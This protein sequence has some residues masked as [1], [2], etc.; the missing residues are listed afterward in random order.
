MSARVASFLEPVKSADCAEWWIHDLGSDETR[1]SSIFPPLFDEFARIPNALDHT[2][3]IARHVAAG[4]FSSLAILTLPEEKSLCAIQ[5]LGEESMAP[6]AGLGPLRGQE[7][8]LYRTEFRDLSRWLTRSA[9]AHE[10]N[11]CDVGIAWPESRAWMMRAERSRSALFVA[12][13]KYLLADV[14]ARLGNGQIERLTHKDQLWQPHGSL[15]RYFGSEFPRF[16]KPVENAEPA[17]WWLGQPHEKG[18]V[19]TLLPPL[20][21]DYV[22]IHMAT[23]E[24]ARYDDPQGCIE[25]WAAARLFAKLDRFSRPEDECL[26]GI[27]VGFNTRA[28]PDTCAFLACRPDKRWPSRLWEYLGGAKRLRAEHITE[29][30][31]GY[32][33][34]RARFGDLREWLQ[35]PTRVREPSGYTPNILWPKHRAWMLSVPY[36]QSVL[37]LGGS[38]SLVESV[39]DVRELQAVR[40]SPSEKR[41]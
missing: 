24:S 23:P 32:W 28:R 19:S 6:A 14:V 8:R 11:G 26:C 38:R 10:P 34:Y 7:Y 35:N 33:L 27:W 21:E 29:Q 4:L 17:E 9:A 40:T 22:R 31:D 39:L 5:T 18:C 13:S 30:P 15:S 37:F 20:F 25:P 12:G 36:N 3:H 16:Y 1:I 41:W 2:G